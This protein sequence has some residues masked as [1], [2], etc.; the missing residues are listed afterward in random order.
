MMMLGVPADSE[1]ASGLTC[2]IETFTCKRR[3]QKRQ[4]GKTCRIQRGNK[5]ANK[6]ATSMPR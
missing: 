2:D 1:C 6:L 4:A 3:V 5:V